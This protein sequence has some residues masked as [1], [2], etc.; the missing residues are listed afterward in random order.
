MVQ[1]I[2]ITCWNSSL[3]SADF[4]PDRAK[5]ASGGGFALLSR[6][7]AEL[8]LLSQQLIDPDCAQLT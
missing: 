3:K 5:L 8:G 2:G 4:S 1:P 6:H 7:K